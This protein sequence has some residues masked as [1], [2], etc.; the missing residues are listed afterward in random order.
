MYSA[1][2]KTEV[3]SGG[4]PYPGLVIMALQQAAFHY[5]ETSLFTNLAR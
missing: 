3:G 1:I 4:P 5:C 2:I